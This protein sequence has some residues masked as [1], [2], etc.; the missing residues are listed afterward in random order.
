MNFE[1]LLS[2]TCFRQYIC[3][4]FMN[5]KILH[6]IKAILRRSVW[7][8]WIGFLAAM[9][10]CEQDKINYD[11][12]LKLEFSTDTVFFDTI[13][14]GDGS[15]TKMFKIYNRASNRLQI[16]Q[17]F[18]SENSRYHVNLD[19]VSAKQ[20]S[21]VM[22]NARDSMIVFVQV[23]VDKRD[24][25][26][27]FLVEDSL[28]FVTNGNKQ[29][30]VLQAYGRDAK[31]L[32]KFVVKNDTTFNPEK[33]FLI[34]DTLKVSKGATLT[35]NAGCQLYFRKTA[36]LYVEGSL[37]VNGTR[38]AYVEFR[39]DRSDYMNTVPPLSYDMASAQWDGI[40][41]AAGSFGNVLHFADIRNTSNGITIDST[42]TDNDCLI[43]EFC[44][45]R[46]SAGNLFTATNA[47][48]RIYNSLI[49]NAGGYVLELSGGDYEFCQNTVANYYSYSWG[50]RTVPISL[51]RDFIGETKIPLKLIASNCIFY[52]NYNNELMF[53]SYDDGSVSD[54]KFVNCLV[55]L[56]AANVT[57]QF[58]NCV[59]DAPLFLFQAWDDEYSEANPHLYD[60][61][62]QNGSPA[63]GAG[64]VTTGQRF[65]E[66][67]DGNPRLS[68][69]NCCI[70]AYEYGY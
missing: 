29:K 43:A 70:G 52:G 33:P 40:R 59:L 47:K 69:N 45:I 26:L 53:E 22:I 57:Q 62:L 7:I 1:L 15:T 49:Y 23:D 12:S 25:N 13:F 6:H 66:D 3:R 54:C 4:R 21:D 34:S 42:V 9:V 67:L 65:P 56:L 37:V 32:D 60:F 41:F 39:G 51:M 48:A 68:G 19:G 55:K 46:N 63:I 5:R 18:L 28:Q 35:I 2:V 50:G 30:V 11:S 44:Y 27:P 64:D 17:V 8:A 16:S 14:T 58:I 31:R 20:F 24:E 10:A 38:E 36:V 61:H